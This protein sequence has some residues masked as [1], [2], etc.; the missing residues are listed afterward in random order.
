MPMLEAGV[1][2]P[3]RGQL[4][5]QP[6]V[7][8]KASHTSDARQNMHWDEFLEH[9][10]EVHKKLKDLFDLIEQ[11]REKEVR[12]T[13]SCTQ[14]ETKVERCARNT[15]ELQSRG[16]AAEDHLKMQSK[17]IEGANESAETVKERVNRLAQEFDAVVATLREEM[18]EHVERH[19][20][21]SHEALRRGDRAVAE[22]VLMKVAESKGTLQ[23]ALT[24]AVQQVRHELEDTRRQ[25]GDTH[26]AALAK[27]ET[28]ASTKFEKFDT[29]HSEAHGRQA[30]LHG[31][32]SNRL[33]V[34]E[35][36]H[37]Q[38]IARTDSLDDKV[39]DGF[40][41]TEERLRSLEL[42]SA[43][44]VMT[45]A[46]RFKE[47]LDEVSAAA[48]HGLHRM[49][50]EV[51][52]D[53]REVVRAACAAC[54]NELREEIAL[55]REQ[56]PDELRG[57]RDDL[58]AGLASCREWSL[59][60]DDTR[61]QDLQTLQSELQTVCREMVDMVQD[62]QR[63]VLETQERSSSTCVALGN[64]LQENFDRS[65]NELREQ[66]GD[67]RNEFG[68][69][70]HGAASASE[71]LTQ[72]IESLSHR[73]AELSSVV[74]TTQTTSETCSKDLAR[75]HA[76]SEQG[77]ADLRKEV[78]HEVQDLSERHA[79]LLSQSQRHVD[80]IQ[81]ELRERTSNL[82]KEIS[83]VASI[84]ERTE[85]AVKS[86][87]SQLG[88][89]QKELARHSASTSNELADLRSAL[90]TDRVD[91]ASVSA[92][93]GSVGRDISPTS[94]GFVEGR[95][96][97][98]NCFGDTT[99]VGMSCSTAVGF[100][101]LATSGS[102]SHESR[103]SRKP[104]PYFGAQAESVTMIATARRARERDD[105][106]AAP[107]LGPATRRALS[108]C[109][110]SVGAIASASLSTRSPR[111]LSSQV[112]SLGCSNNDR[113]WRHQGEPGEHSP[114]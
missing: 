60:H 73:L 58:R 50:G 53:V 16:E 24:L 74:S 69:E 1:L 41:K 93:T 44:L 21:V 77:F 104:A 114:R 62:L 98:Q 67:V 12:I 65:F 90:R 95:H 105:R 79:A 47:E 18:T 66:L 81:H 23:E 36:S 97:R 56:L 99:G 101:D 14:L 3:L 76:A 83:D 35:H 38:F 15:K 20:Q 87:G 6:L 5:A 107:L 111:A 112:R 33:D 31:E 49:R 9:R 52:H 100:S 92:C 29:R 103:G 86:H 68:K 88:M 75:Y 51:E 34:I 57:A 64:K 84:L 82:Q 42:S 11:R 39:H 85:H 109:D 19:Q 54:T 108:G 91:R 72:S 106:G 55:V 110:H 37:K 78:A 48:A 30:K 102:A 63:Q 28:E 7:D 4:Q 89:A 40:G 8:A 61:N 17:A 22:E 25:S 59:R 80:A 26:A 46:D 113:L 2:S 96:M 13:R 71:S 43:N 32:A 27:S 10:K 70:A 45:T 94:R